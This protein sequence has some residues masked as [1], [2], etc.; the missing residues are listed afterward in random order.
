MFCLPRHPDGVFFV[1]ILH[2]D[3]K[4]FTFATMKLT[5][6]GN[7]TLRDSRCKEIIYKFLEKN[8]VTEIHTSGET[9]GICELAREI[10][11][12]EAITLVLKFADN[13][14]YAAGKYEHRA[15]DILK[16]SDF[17]IF[18]HDGMSK[19]TLNELKM[20]QKLKIPFE[21]HKIEL[22]DEDDY[23]FE[24]DLKDIE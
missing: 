10:A 17:V 3:K 13:K 20:A 1:K 8:D 19:G 9:S 4:R 2:T 16:H 23:L 22:T 12:T 5:I 18:I 15:K 21:Y 14:K 6:F 24:W 11:K 7:R